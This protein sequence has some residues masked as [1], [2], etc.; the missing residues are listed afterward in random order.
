MEDLLY[1]PLAFLDPIL[2]GVKEPRQSKLLALR[3]SAVFDAEV[4]LVVQILDDPVPKGD[5]GNPLSQEDAEALRAA[6]AI[7][8]DLEKYLV[9]LREDAL[10]SVR[11]YDERRRIVL[12]A[13]DVLVNDVT[14]GLRISNDLLTE[15]VYLETIESKGGDGPFE[16]DGEKRGF[17]RALGRMDRIHAEFAKI[18]EP[19][20]I[21]GLLENVR[22]A[23]D[24]ATS[25][26]IKFFS[27][28]L[29]EASAKNALE[30][31]HPRART[32]A[33][34]GLARK[35]ATEIED[36]R[37][38]VD[39][40]MVAY[41]DQ[42][43]SGARESHKFAEEIEKL[44]RE[45]KKTYDNREHHLRFYEGRQ[46][47]QKTP[48]PGL[49]AEPAEE[50]TEKKEEIVPEEPEPN[51]PAEGPKG[52][53]QNATQ[54][55]K[56]MFSGTKSPE[57]SPPEI[58][59]LVKASCVVTVSKEIGTDWNSSELALKVPRLQ[60]AEPG[61]GSPDALIFVC[62][63]VNLDESLEGWL[64]T[65]KKKGKSSF[66]IFRLTFFR[67]PPPWEESTC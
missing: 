18:S 10:E 40:N 4:E 34:E 49:L 36:I 12:S 57:K 55:F 38:I 31:L 47:A 19:D 17:R 51:E 3:K 1:L 37:D 41:F 5:D 8:K 56:K 42:I 33:L 13:R 22:K 29:D 53:V 45:E 27:N 28:A 16:N 20:R 32:A 62:D 6:A 30:N 61:E 24:E 60:V 59:T 46:V 35:N 58:E 66:R 7:S 11:F 25:D 64:E 65:M 63:D 52:F 23:A 2:H 14:E 9:N 50:E 43:S 54:L 48:P 21:K 44:A 39:R 67:K 15:D 26:R